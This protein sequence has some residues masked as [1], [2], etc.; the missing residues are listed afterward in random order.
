MY[1]GLFDFHVAFDLDLALSWDLQILTL[2]LISKNKPKT[3]AAK[4]AIRLLSPRG[5]E[6]LSAIKNRVIHQELTI[7]P[8]VCGLP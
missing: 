3:V 2:N 5:S 8:K 7:P 1:L 4:F 6:I